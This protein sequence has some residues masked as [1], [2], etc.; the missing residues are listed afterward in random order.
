MSASGRRVGIREVAAEAGVSTATV[1]NA[2]NRTGR[3]DPRTR[4]RVVAVASRLG[5]RASPSARQLRGRRTGVLAVTA[6]EPSTDGYGLMDVEYFVEVLMAAAAVAL[7]RGYS[8]TIVPGSTA[9][10]SLSGT[11]VDGVLLFDV[12]RADPLL[13]ELTAAGT[14]VVTVGRDTSVP[15]SAGWWVDDDMAAGTTAL[16]DHLAS[17]GARRVALV[18]GPRDYSYCA[19]AEDAYLAWAD[20]QGRP[21]LVAHVDVEPG[22]DAAR[23]LLDRADPP[24][25]VC[26]V[27]ERYALATLAVAEEYGVRVPADLAVAAGSD[28]PAARNG[29]TPVTV[30]DL[31][32]DQV[33]RDAVDLLL[34]RIDGTATAPAHRLVTADVVARAST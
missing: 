17:T 20:A 33:G 13:A 11:A 7:D 32:P 24:D 3:I 2:L 30:L 1:S 14:P 34:A 9:T 5:Y 27:V 25:A 18:T 29:R 15:A 12:L 8:L 16:L 28:S 31:H 6:R 4:D 19:D 21:S 10:T 22:H 23:S 26:A